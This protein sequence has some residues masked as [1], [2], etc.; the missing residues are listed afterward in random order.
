MH[1]KSH[2]RRVQ[3]RKYSA[4]S[5]RVDVFDVCEIRTRLRSDDG[6]QLHQGSLTWDCEKRSI[7]PW[8]KNR[9]MSGINCILRGMA[10]GLIGDLNQLRN[11]G[12][13]INSHGT[14]TSLPDSFYNDFSMQK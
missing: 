6:V 4:S 14:Y 8:R 9:F 7:I 5:S 10:F 11:F 12:N 3:C 1:F 13:D 2:R